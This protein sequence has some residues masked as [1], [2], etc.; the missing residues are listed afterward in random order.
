MSIYR[1]GMSAHHY[2]QEH[3][4]LFQQFHGEYLYLRV[5]IHVFAAL[6]KEESDET[7][8]IFDHIGAVVK[9]LES[10]LSEYK[11]YARER[12]DEYCH[13]CEKFTGTQKISLVELESILEGSLSTVTSPGITKSERPD[14]GNSDTFKNIK[15]V[16]SK[17]ES[18]W[19]AKAW[20][21]ALFDRPKFEVA[22]AKFRDHNRLLKDWEY[23]IVGSIRFGL[24]IELGAA[25]QRDPES[26]SRLSS[27]AMHAG[28]SKII[29]ST[30]H[31]NDCPD[32]STTQRKFSTSAAA[33]EA[34]K[35]TVSPAQHPRALHSATIT[36]RKHY[37]SDPGPQRGTTILM[38]KQL[39]SLLLEAGTHGHCTLP[40]KRVTDDPGNSLFTFEFGFPQG[41]TE[42][43]PIS[44][45]AL[46]DSDQASDMLS[47]PLRFHIALTISRAVG[48]LH[49]DGWLHKSIRSESL[50]FFFNEQGRCI[51]KDPYLVNFEY[52]RPEAAGTLLASDNKLE[53][54][55]YR[56]PD[57]QGSPTV[58]FNKMH[59]LY[60]LGVVLLEIG[61]WETAESMR[62]DY[63]LRNNLKNTGKVSSEMRD[64][65]LQKAEERLGHTMGPLYKEAVKACLSGHL[66]ESLH[67]RS[68]ALQFQKSVIKNIQAERIGEL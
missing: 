38:L 36:E 55:L 47:L 11:I 34:T 49:A 22:L 13:Q 28:I 51:Y 26:D 67:S 14:G 2:K 39:E 53:R 68:F 7:E 59:D 66:N 16:F 61:V 8:M 42:T 17:K 5:F 3:D 46:I 45:L 18:I 52:A 21:W 54:N 29:D 63:L 20:A 62:E 1:L 33:I 25:I 15:A 57:R 6:L 27:F 56:H 50:L 4:W 31:S 64:M 32:D 9:H 37:Y 19:K 30:N 12:D 40:L 65:F 44:L 24:K 58:A 41:T 48:A 43:T 23:V 60:S 10:E 35:A